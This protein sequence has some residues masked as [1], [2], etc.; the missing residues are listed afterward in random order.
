MQRE[1]DA[2]RFVQELA[3]QFRTI[4]T[5][6]TLEAG[7]RDPDSDLNAP[8][9]LLHAVE[10]HPEAIGCR[11]VYGGLDGVVG[12]ILEMEDDPHRTVYERAFPVAFQFLRDGGE[13]LH[14]LDLRLAGSLEFDGK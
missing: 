6:G 9:G 1:G 7:A 4:G 10:R 2:L 12:L 14:E 8:S 13:R 5:Q 3:R 11:S